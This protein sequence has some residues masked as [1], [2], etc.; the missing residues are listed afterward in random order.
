MGYFFGGALFQ[1]KGTQGIILFFVGD[2]P[3][4]KVVFGLHKLGLNK[5][6]LNI[7]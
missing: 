2:V 6:M 1:E 3:F 7:I 4:F 5:Y